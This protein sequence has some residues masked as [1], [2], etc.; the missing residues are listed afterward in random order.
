MG[1]ASNSPVEVQHFL[2]SRVVMPVNEGGDGCTL[3]TSW[4]Q[5]R[6]TPSAG[7]QRHLGEHE[8]QMYSGNIVFLARFHGLLSSTMRQSVE[9][10][11]QIPI[12]ALQ[13]CHPRQL[14]QVLQSALVIVIQNL[15]NRFSITGYTQLQATSHAADHLATSGYIWLRATRHLQQHTLSQLHLATSY[16]AGFQKPSKN[17]KFEILLETV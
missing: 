1:S 2:P 9:C 8:C 7:N 17:P 10:S 5:Q 3:H 13:S 12:F 14:P 4:D 11:N 6:A 15:L 16:K